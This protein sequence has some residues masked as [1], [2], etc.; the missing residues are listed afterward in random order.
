MLDQ[1][2]D[3]GDQKREQSDQMIVLWIN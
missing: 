2:G 1:N 3:N